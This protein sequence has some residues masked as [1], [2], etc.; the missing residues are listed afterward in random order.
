MSKRGHVSF[1]SFVTLESISVASGGLFDGYI[2]VCA[3]GYSEG[4]TRNAVIYSEWKRAAPGQ[5][6]TGERWHNSWA[7]GQQNL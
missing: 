2:G 7:V 1:V 4:F 3:E 5:L 6:R